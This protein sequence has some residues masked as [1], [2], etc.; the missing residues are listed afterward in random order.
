MNDYSVESTYQSI[1]QNSSVKDYKTEGAPYTKG[2]SPIF[3]SSKTNNGYLLYNSGMSSISLASTVSKID[4]TN[5]TIKSCTVNS[6]ILDLYEI[7]EGVIAYQRAGGK[8]K[9]SN[10]VIIA[11]YDKILFSG[12]FNVLKIVGIVLSIV[13]LILLVI[14]MLCWLKEG[15]SLKAQKVGK[16]ILRDWK[17]YFAMIP[18]I[19]LLFT[20]VK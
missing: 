19:V 3:Y 15:F 20:F 14:M 18:S 13:T 12:I 6:T 16:K 1:S 5:N 2:R 10:V 7:D 4:F 9:E 11:D 17:I 8:N